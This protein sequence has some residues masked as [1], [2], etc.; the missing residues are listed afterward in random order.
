MMQTCS[1]SARLGSFETV[2]FDGYGIPAG[3]P[4]ARLRRRLPWLPIV[5][6]RGPPD[7]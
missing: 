7:F 2:G 4:A 3:L 6:G 5:R 1:P